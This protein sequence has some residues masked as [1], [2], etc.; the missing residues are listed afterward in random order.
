M[1]RTLFYGMVLD[2][3]TPVLVPVDSVAELSDIPLSANFA[4]S[5]NVPVQ[6]PYSIG[7]E[8]SSGSTGAGTLMLSIS[9]FSNPASWVDI[10][11]VAIADGTFADGTRSLFVYNL[12]TGAAQFGYLG[13]PLLQ[14]L[15]LLV[16]LRIAP[17][18]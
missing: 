4:A 9:S 13:Q 3:G 7:V 15:A 6:Y 17:Q 10:Q 1:I 14:A 18:G 2:S 5:A 12:P 8:L 16:L 11:P